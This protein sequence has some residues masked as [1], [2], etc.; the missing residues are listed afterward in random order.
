MCVSVCRR[1][2]SVQ[3][4]DDLASHITYTFAPDEHHRS[5]A[6]WGSICS[7]SSSFD[8]LPHSTPHIQTRTH[9]II[10]DEPTHKWYAVVALQMTVSSGTMSTMNAHCDFDVDYQTN[11]YFILRTMHLQLCTPTM[12]LTMAANCTRRGQT[13][14]S[15]QALPDVVTGQHIEH[16][17]LP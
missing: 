1:L 9:R 17:A 3:G 16:L 13:A 7:Y 15:G 4:L 10:G 12:H 2:S 6:L 8:K 14:D 5:K 11:K